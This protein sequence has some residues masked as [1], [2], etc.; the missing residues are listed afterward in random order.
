VN[1]LYSDVTLLEEHE[2]VVG[3]CRAMVGRIALN[4]RLYRRAGVGFAASPQHTLG[5]HR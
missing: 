1:R 5:I 3:D 4:Y 2:D